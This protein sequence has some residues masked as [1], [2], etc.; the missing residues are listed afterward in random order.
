MTNFFWM[1]LTVTVM[2]SEW[3]GVAIDPSYQ[4]SSG[5]GV[6]VPGGY[7]KMCHA[8]QSKLGRNYI[9]DGKSR[10]TNLHTSTGIQHL[11]DAFR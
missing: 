5:I 4:I 8:W 10:N 3:A 11:M 9:F 6:S 7:E 2:G 1:Q